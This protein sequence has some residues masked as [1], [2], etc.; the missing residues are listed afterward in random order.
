MFPTPGAVVRTTY[1]EVSR[2]A[3][4]HRRVRVHLEEPELAAGIDLQ[5][6]EVPPAVRRRSK[7]P[8]SRRVEHRRSRD[9]ASSDNARQASVSASVPPA[10]AWDEQRKRRRRPLFIHETGSLRRAARPP[11][12]APSDDKQ[13]WIGRLCCFRTKGSTV[14]TQTAGGRASRT[15]RRSLQAIAIARRRLRCAVATTRKRQ[16]AEHF[17]CA[18]NHAIANATATGGVALFGSQAGLGRAYA[19]V[20]SWDPRGAPAARPKRACVVREPRRPLVSRSG[21]AAR[22]RASGGVIRGCRPTRQCGSSDI[23]RRHPRHEGVIALAGSARYKNAHTADGPVWSHPRGP[24]GTCFRRRRARRS[25]LG[26]R[27]FTTSTSMRRPPNGLPSSTAVIVG[28][29]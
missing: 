17:G 29:V 14:V 25:S 15:Y 21:T 2:H 1:G 4:G 5:E 9:E 20:P 8:V 3:L 10:L 27:P 12:A 11:R 7:L 13:S 6:H 23:A 28:P 18:A 24:T 22:C 19:S 16:C 26:G